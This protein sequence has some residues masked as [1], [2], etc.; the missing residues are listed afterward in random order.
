MRRGIGFV[1]TACALM[2]PACALAQTP[3]ILYQ[4]DPDSP[5][6][7]MHET[8]PPETAQ[9]DFLIGDWDVD[10]VLHQPTGDLAYKARWHNHWIVDGHAIMQEWRGPYATGAEFR[11]YNDKA[12]RWEG[13][14]FYA[15]RQTWTESTG[16]FENG[17]FIVITGEA[18][19]NGAFTNK[20]RYFDIKP[21]S[22][23]MMAVRS[24]DGGE[25]WTEEPSYEMTCTL[26]G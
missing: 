10:I 8:A 22:F 17:E 1:V 18:G 14:N 11:S 15:G 16:T 23:R 4:P 19:A 13:R 3:P 21:G 5:I 24:F 26:V 9:M 7:E 2:A 20:E 25:T 12:Q 6:G